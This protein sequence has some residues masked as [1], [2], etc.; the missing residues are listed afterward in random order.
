MIA[1]YIDENCRVLQHQ[2]GVL[3]SLLAAAKKTVILP[4]TKWHDS[5]NRQAIYCMPDYA[6][7]CEEQSS[8]RRDG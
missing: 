8:T 1:T 3:T 7:Q 6:T 4:L 2:T 5:I